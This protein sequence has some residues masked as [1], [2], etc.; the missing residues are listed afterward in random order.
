[1]SQARTV[2]AA[3]RK[4]CVVPSV[5][6]KLL[7]SAEAALKAASCATGTV[8]K[9]YS[10]TLPVGYVISETPAAGKKLAVGRKVALVVSKGP[11][12]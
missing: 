8:S 5:T 2:T 4:A 6:G 9:A 10:S 1:M 7:S 12:G 11:A 3:F